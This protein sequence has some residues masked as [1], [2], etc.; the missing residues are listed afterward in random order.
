MRRRPRPIVVAAMGAFCVLS[1]MVQGQ[2]GVSS[3]E[4]GFEVASVRIAAG[5][6]SSLRIGRDRII[7]TNVSLTTLV[8]RAYGYPRS[9]VVGLP[10][11]ADSALFD[12]DAKSSAE[13][14]PDEIDAML[15]TLLRQRFRLEVER[16]KRDV[17]F[18]V[19]SVIDP[20]GKLG[21]GLRPSTTDCSL[22][23][24][25][26]ERWNRT[27]VGPVPSDP[28]CQT[29]TEWKAG[30]VVIRDR[31]ATVA[32]LVRVL[33]TWIERPIVDETGLA[34]EYEV[35]IEAGQDTLPFYMRRRPLDAPPSGGPSLVSALR[36]HLGLRLEAQKGPLDVL[37]VKSVERV[38]T[39][40]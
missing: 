12:I 3:P 26:F 5:G 18:Y 6:R 40:N 16:I 20:D 37:V 23:R 39:A 15:R 33:S 10:A 31:A 29:Q 24:E 21:A 27:R 34:G 30:T 32:G 17:E 8:L 1:G 19:L 35:E 38:P 13:A 22:F 14:S 11:W 36:E 9:R 25:E 28:N 7:A 4:P 2:R